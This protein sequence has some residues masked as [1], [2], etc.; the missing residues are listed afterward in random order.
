MTSIMLPI[1]SVLVFSVATLV[2]TGCKEA[3]D[4]A[5]TAADSVPNEQEQGPAAPRPEHERRGFDV[6]HA[7]FPLPI[8]F[9]PKRAGQWYDRTRLG[10]LNRVAQ[11]LSG[12]CSRNAWLLSKEFFTR[13]DP[14]E[15]E[16]LIQVVDRGLQ[17]NTNDIVETALHAMARVGDP[18]FAPAIQRALNKPTQGIESAAT[19]ALAT[20]SSVETLEKARELILGWSSTAR[21]FWFEAAL[22]VMPGER[23]APYVHAALIDGRF[24]PIWVK[25]VEKSLEHLA[26]EHA[27]VALQSMVETPPPGLDGTMFALRHVT[28]DAGG[29]SRMQEMLRADSPKSRQLALEALNIGGADAFR[30]RVFELTDDPSP[31]VRFAAMEVMDLFE[32]D[33]NVDPILE[34]LATDESVRVRQAALYRLRFRGRRAMLDDLI[35]EMRTATGSQLTFKMGDLVA[36]Q[37]AAAI[38][39]IVERMNAVPVH[40]RRPFLQSIAHMQVPE[41]FPPLR[42]AFLGEAVDLDESDAPGTQL[43][44]RQYLGI[45]LV[46]LRGAETQVLE[47]FRSIDR[48]DYVRRAVLLTTLASIAADRE[49]AEISGPIHDEFRKILFDTTEMPQMRL[50]ALAYLKR[51]ITLADVMKLKRQ[52]RREEDSMQ[53]ALN[54]FL[55]EYF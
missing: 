2:A 3:T 33:E 49:D 51:G 36:A 27:I 14:E 52:V 55:L 39:V 15:A 9:S 28:G 37:D 8:E 16:V 4:P 24:R 22:K 40:E 46:N 5:V 6:W 48:A 34:T 31:A 12:T 53:R 45:L 17:A 13:V 43:E 19:R 20:C 23:V 50:S 41:G 10:A 30:Q 7:D 18:R 35:D 25:L 54:D 38:P 47:L 1:R 44:S 11:N 26:P 29:T 21:M 32:G 42:D